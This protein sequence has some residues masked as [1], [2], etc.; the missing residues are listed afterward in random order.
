MRTSSASH[1]SWQYRFDDGAQ[2]RLATIANSA[3]STE[4]SKWRPSTCSAMSSGSPTRRHRCSSTC[5]SPYGQVSTSRNAGSL[6]RSSSDEQRFRMLR[7]KR[8]SRSALLGSSLRPQLYTMRT[9]ERFLTGSHTF[10]AICRWLSTEPSARFWL[11]WRRY[12]YLRIPVYAPSYNMLFTHVCIY[13]NRAQISCRAPQS[14]DLSTPCLPSRPEMYAQLSNSGGIPHRNPAHDHECRFGFPLLG[15]VGRGCARRRHCR[16]W[17]GPDLVDTD[18][19]SVDVP[20]VAGG[21][22]AAFV[23]RRPGGGQA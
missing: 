7:A 2:H 4:N 3:R 6:A 18:D 9:R 10:S 13:V 11:D 1:C 15:G 23:V 22:L 16:E 21:G 5:T 12:M 20:V 19:G 14:L 8:R 17:S